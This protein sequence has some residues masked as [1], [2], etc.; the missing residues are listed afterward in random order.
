MRIRRQKSR[1][2]SLIEVLV[3][4]AVIALLAALL[5]PALGIARE[6]ART[7]ACLS[8]LRQIHGSIMLYTYDYEG[9]F[10][11]L[12]Y[13]V[14][15]C[16]TCQDSIFGVLVTQGYINAPISPST[17]VLLDVKTIL[18]CPSG[19]FELSKP[20]VKPGDTHARP[21]SSWDPECH[22]ATAWRTTCFGQTGWIH[23]WYGVN[24][25]SGSG[26]TYKNPFTRHPPDP[27]CG[28]PTVFHR[29][30]SVTI[31][32]Q[33]ILSYDGVWAH[34]NWTV[35]DRVSARHFRVG[36]TNQLPGATNLI[37][38]DGHGETVQTVQIPAPAETP[39]VG[40]RFKM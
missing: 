31:P 10:P 16:G 8:N 26:A 5:L 36:E 33:L 39:S 11:P 1:A 2:F 35:N 12:D 34:N 28:T 25:S 30:Q 40:P 29:R 18:R 21:W 19:I 9:Y 3:V 23:G 20:S 32:T 22:K 24:G 6:R 4:L 15:N 27:G 17:T 38:M 7:V 14:T 37:M 13:S